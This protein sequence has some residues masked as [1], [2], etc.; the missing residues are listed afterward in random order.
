MCLNVIGV[1]I[2][3][4]NYAQVANY[5]TKA[6]QNM[7]ST[8][9]WISQPCATATSTIQPRTVVPPVFSTW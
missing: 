3:L 7:V 6:E 2:E 9:R 1:S 4:S 5:V 8:C